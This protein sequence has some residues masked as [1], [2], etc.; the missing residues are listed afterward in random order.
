[1]IYDTLVVVAAKDFPRLSTLYPRLYE[2]LESRKLI[3]VGS[4]EVG[5]LL[6]DSTVAAQAEWL[7]EDQII[8]FDAVHRLM[9][10][11]LA[12]L[13]QG[14]ELPRG[15]TG[16]YYQQFLKMQY[17]RDCEDEYYMVWD[18]DTVPCRDIR[19]FKEGSGEAFLDLKTEYKAQYFE[20]MGRLIP[21]LKKFIAKSFISEHM[22]IKCEY[23]KEL[24]EEIEANEQIAG[25]TFWEKILNAIPMERLQDAVFSE[26]ETY[27]SFVALRHSSAYRLREWH[28]FRLGGEF[29]DP[30][31]ISERDFDWLG[32]DF[33]AISFEKGHSVRED[34]KNLFDNPYYQEKLSPRQMLEA[35]QPEFNGGYVEVWDQGS[36]KGKEEEPFYKTAAS[37]KLRYLSEEAYRGYEKLGERLIDENPIQAAL[38][39]EQAAFLAK[40]TAEAER[41]GTRAGSIKARAPKCCIVILSFNQRYL[42]QMCLESIYTNCVP[43]SF[44]IVVLD[45]A[46]TD[47]SAEW[48]AAQHAPGLT[49][50]LKDENLGFAGGCNA[51]LAFCPPGED[52][53]FLNNDTRLPAAALFWL[54]MALYA[55]EKTGAVGGMQ[56]YGKAE[57]RIDAEFAAPEQYME[58]GAGNNVDMP[59]ARTELPKLSGF[60]LLVRRT[61][62]DIT[63]G[64]DERFSPGY[65]EDDDLCIRIRKKGFHLY[66]CKNAY[67][68]HAGSQSFVKRPDVE[69]L[70]LRNR[71]R[72]IEK[73]GFDS[74]SITM[75]TAL[76]PDVSEIKCI[77]WDLDN[78][79]WEGILSEEKVNWSEQ[80]TALIQA[81]ADRGIINSIC[82]KN[83]ES[84]VCEEFS[85]AGKDELRSLFVF[86]SINWESKGARLK[87]Q[88]VDMALRPEN[89]LFID[90][91]ETNLREAKYLMPDLKTAT[92]DILTG[93]SDAILALPVSDIG[94]MRLEQYRLLEAKRSDQRISIS[95]EQFLKE[96]DIRVSYDKDC[97]KHADRIAELIKRTNQLNFTKYRC[98]K[99][100]LEELLLDESFECALVSVRDKYGDYGKVGFYAMEKEAPHTLIHFLFSCRVLGM[101]IE[102]YTY[103]KLGCPE[104]LLSGSTAVKL[105]KDSLPD[106][107][108]EEENTG[109]SE[110]KKQ[111]EKKQRI[112]LKGPCDID[113]ITPYLTDCGFQIDLETNFVDERGVIVAGS[114]NTIHWYALYNENRE[115]LKEAIAQ[116]P[117]LCAADFA[118]YMLQDDYD[119]IVYSTL[120]DGHGGVYRN[121]KNGV[122]ISFSGCNYDLTDPDNWGKFV[123][124]E[125]VNH[126]YPFTR[127]IL[128]DFAEHYEF[129]GS[130]DPEEVAEDL[131]WLRRKLRP[132]C[133]LILLLGSEIEAEDNIEEFADH[134]HRYRRLNEAIRSRLGKEQG[135]DFVNITDLITGQDCFEGA[136]NHF[137]R[138][139]YQRIAEEIKCIL[140]NQT[141]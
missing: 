86:T 46:S 101:G 77:V 139:V 34:H 85:S 10:S 87:Q 45:N 47:G 65:Y 92:P 96:S 107:I 117:F 109:I 78:C 128:E 12:P 23:M 120:S 125:Y 33:D 26:F 13:L 88:I 44:S 114:N 89:I 27:G 119:A 111:E 14:R 112:L 70:I 76:L 38:C 98:D 133:R 62:L 22:L 110:E 105:K 68:Y 2:K 136:T 59:D 115:K 106:W 72:F 15:V 124:G 123:S 122:K 16:W 31:T 30:Q 71:Q 58:F 97:M 20:T 100:A 5:E 66:A 135:V 4:K 35:V 19:M 51:A 49:V 21:G 129:V 74:T 43:G 40:D 24:M 48:L 63:G 8:P 91:E 134:A 116:A 73:W 29:F 18:G 104:I 113:G 61:L 93:L 9:S 102:Q 82:S 130:A 137:S 41:I 79:F 108:R 64:F 53:L 55:D 99:D 118:T 17:A 32:R 138:S 39:F 3:F 103:Q 7:D 80:N 126:N 54:R 52:I 1:M 28:S 131:L 11:R 84:S 69:T 140:G 56:S 83:D 6:T 90:D 25:S 57:Q 132:E 127:K 75:D 121:R 37:G 141:C 94:H 95:N 42:T 36:T 50:I 81:A 67:I 60:A